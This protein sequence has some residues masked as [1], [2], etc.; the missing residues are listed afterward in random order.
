MIPKN[1]HPEYSVKLGDIVKALSKAKPLF[2]R[3]KS[4][5]LYR[6]ERNKNKVVEK[7]NVDSQTYKI[8][9]N[10]LL[11]IEREEYKD[12]KEILNK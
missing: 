11:N 8:I 6:N 1:R 7:L 10:N 4:V 12:L 2:Y 5:Q 3:K 9:K